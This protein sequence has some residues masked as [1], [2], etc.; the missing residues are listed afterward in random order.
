MGE[1]SVDLRLKLDKLRADAAKA[2]RDINSGLASSVKG[3]KSSSEIAAERDRRINRDAWAAKRADLMEQDKMRGTND[4]ARF[5]RMM[6]A[7]MLPMLRPT[8]PWG[9]FFA[10]RQ[11]FQ[12]FQGTQA[13]QGAM[14]K[15]GLSGNAGAGIAAA[16]ITALALAVGVALRGLKTALE[17]VTRAAEDAR[18]TYA[19]ILQ[20]G[21]MATGFIVQRQQLAQVLGVSDAEVWQYGTAIGFLNSK[22]E[23][24]TKIITDTN[25]TVTALGWEFQITKE[26]MKAMWSQLAQDAAPAIEVF[27]RAFD[28]FI[29]HLTDNSFTKGL[30][31]MADNNA[32]ANK[33]LEFYKKFGVGM[34]DGKFTDS[35]GTILSKGL[36][37]ILS[38]KYEKFIAG[39]GVEKAPPPTVSI[40]RLPTSNWEKMGLIIGGGG[41]VDHQKKIANNTTQMVST[42][43]KIATSLGVPRSGQGNFF[44]N[45]MYSQP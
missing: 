17:G 28:E 9:T 5:E 11:A 18:Q 13:G 33:G 31:Q 40:N 3:L 10:S 27:L 34:S 42:L 22:L 16:G 36:Q 2:G 15:F 32:K 21:G 30:I 39:A 37:K 6:M 24:S 14:G 26:N 4:K 12:A 23:W 44:D 43:N 45:P 20:S 7:S 1:V 35:A 38:E 19:K 25:P 8:S 41:L 29:K